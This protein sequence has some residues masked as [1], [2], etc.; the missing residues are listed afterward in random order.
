M[1]IIK[2]LQV[3]NNIK[4]G[5]YNLIGTFCAR[6][7]P[8]LTAIFRPNPSLSIRAAQK[9]TCMILASLRAQC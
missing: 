9:T 2:T 3:D 6:L 5:G 1:S 4:Q 8:L 7:F